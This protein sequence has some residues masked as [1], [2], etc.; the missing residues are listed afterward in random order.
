MKIKRT[1]LLVKD[2]RRMSLNTDFGDT[3]GIDD[4]PFIISLNHYQ[5]EIQLAIVEEECSAFV[6]YKEIDI[7]AATESYPVPSDAFIHNLVYGIE[8]SSSGNAQD[9]VELD[10]G[11]CRGNYSVG[12]PDAYVIEGGRIYL[13]GVR[14]SAQGKLRVRYEK[15]LDK[16]DKRRGTIVSRSISGTYVNPTSIVLD[17]DAD[18]TALT[19]AEYVCV[20]D[21]Y[22]TVKMRNIPISEWDSATF[23]ITIQSDFTAD[24]DMD[25][26]FGAGDFITI[27]EDSTTHS[28]LV[29]PCE[30]FLVTGAVFDAQRLHSS[31][32]SEAENSKMNR[33]KKA[34]VAVYEKLPGG[35]QSIP[36]RR[37]W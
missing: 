7:T 24:E 10:D 23:T 14:S 30:S 9:Y 11:V 31:T 19:E 28:N 13:D 21:K 5:N 16:L 6:A 17:T 18:D 2:A 15:G 8:Y 22:G 36:E 20:N 37:I 4:E 3:Y 35:K 32:D 27:G 34:I 33:L 1:D 25:V 12:E 29:Y 26:D